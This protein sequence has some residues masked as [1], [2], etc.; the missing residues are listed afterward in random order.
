[1]NRWTLRF[2]TGHGA[3][4]AE[5]VTAGLIHASRSKSLG[6]TGHDTPTK[7]SSRSAT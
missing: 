5:N 4:I 1:M 6:L 2:Q 7:R 3:Y